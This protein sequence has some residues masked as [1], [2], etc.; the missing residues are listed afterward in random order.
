VRIVARGRFEK[1]AAL[2]AARKA[3]LAAEEHGI[4]RFLFDARRA[5]NPASLIANYDFAYHDLASIRVPRGIRAALLVVE[6]D[7][8][9]DMA[10]TLCRIAGYVVRLFRDEETAAGWLQE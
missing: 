8:S 4:G 2:G 5:P 1:E 3:R 6:G 9:Y 10:E 7:H